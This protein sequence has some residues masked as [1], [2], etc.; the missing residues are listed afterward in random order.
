MKWITRL[1]GKPSEPALAALSPETALT[2]AEI[3]QLARE[4][5]A[6]EGDLAIFENYKNGTKS[7]DFLT[8]LRTATIPS[9]STQMDTPR[10][11]QYSEGIPVTP[12]EQII[13][14]QRPLIGKIYN[15]SGMIKEDFLALIVPIIWNFAGL[16]HLLPASQGNHH[17][18]PGGAF[19]HGLEVAYMAMEATYNLYI[20]TSVVAPKYRPHVLKQWQMAIFV[21]AIGH[22]LGKL[23]T[24]FYVVAAKDE[25]AQTWNPFTSSLYDWAI[26]NKL[27]R[28]YLIWVSRRYRLHEGKGP[29]LLPMLVSRVHM[30]YLMMY[31]REPVE[32]MMACLTAPDPSNNLIARVVL[33][34][35][36]KSSEADTRS[37]VQNENDPGVIMEQAERILVGTVRRLWRENKWRINEPGGR[38]WVPDD[39]TVYVVWDAATKDITK[40]LARHTG[41]AMLPDEPEVLAAL[42]VESGIAKAFVYQGYEHLLHSIRIPS[43]ATSANPEGP[44]Y[45]ALKA[46][47]NGLMGI[48]TAPSYSTVVEVNPDGLAIEGKDPGKRPGAQSEPV[49]E[50]KQAKQ[51]KEPQASKD[52]VESKADTEHAGNAGHATQSS[53]DFTDPST[54]A[55]GVDGP[56]SDECSANPTPSPGEGAGRPASKQPQGSERT[57]RAN[58]VKSARANT[59]SGTRCLQW[60]DDKF[61]PFSDL[62]VDGDDLLIPVGLAESTMGL[63]GPELLEALKKNSLISQKPRKQ[64]SPVLNVEGERFFL[65]QDPLIVRKEVNTASG[66]GMQNQGSSPS[67]SP[68]VNQASG[69]GREQDMAPG[70]GAVSGKHEE[71]LGEKKPNKPKKKDASPG[72]TKSDK[73][74]PNKAAT[75]SGSRNN[76]ADPEDESPVRTREPSGDETPYEFYRRE[77]WL[78][79]IE[80]SQSEESDAVTMEMLGDQAA[81]LK[82]RFGLSYTRPKLLNKI[83]GDEQFYM[84]TPEGIFIRR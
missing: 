74:K 40:E 79:F 4:Y 53:L 10:Y 7:L 80:S 64:N 30:D 69:T 55:S 39:R 75:R 26:Q 32:A 38:L 65:L 37:Q 61:I 66:D 51:P 58:P 71:G 22:D 16:V 6:G 41:K 50:K 48:V 45:Y 84:N 81:W 35:D 25:A 3:T 11:P 17:P 59:R 13:A 70:N 20:P 42:L 9:T 68:S 49:E 54:D 31:T 47:L 57:E 15:A 67:S 56:S 76:Q 82:E 60:P 62:K 1:F 24:D 78:R 72:R 43:L 73:Q 27:K 5:L 8:G 36:A 2:E 19:R 18:G 33:E 21:A 77:L 63:K 44:L 14:S 28:Y 29:V 12:L 52:N 46:D 83:G 23:L 34:A